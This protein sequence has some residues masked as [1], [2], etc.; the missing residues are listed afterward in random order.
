LLR[1]YDLAGKRSLIPDLEINQFVDVKDFRENKR[2]WYIS[3]NVNGKVPTLVDSTSHITMW[4]SCAIVNYL[5]DRYDVGKSSI[6][7]SVSS[8]F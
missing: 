5:L 4:D 8:S 3:L 7:E 2:D 1:A 6:D